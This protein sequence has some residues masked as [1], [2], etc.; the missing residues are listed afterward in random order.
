MPCFDNLKKK[1]K[2]R[3]G[4]ETSVARILCGILSGGAAN[5]KHTFIPISK[6][7]CMNSCVSW[8]TR[9]IDLQAYAA[10]AMAPI[11]LP[12]L[13]RNRTKAFFTITETWTRTSGSVQWKVNEPKYEKREERGWSSHFHT[14]WALPNNVF[15]PFAKST[16]YCSART[17]GQTRQCV[18]IMGT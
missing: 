13:G 5:T 6:M 8:R 15:L 16:Y 2:Q 9:T 7:K 18:I 4:F 11:P 12:S 3:I 17:A 14:R 1:K 10:A